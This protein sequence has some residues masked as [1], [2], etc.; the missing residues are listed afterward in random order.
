MPGPWSR[1]KRDKNKKKNPVKKLNVKNKQLREICT[2]DQKRLD[3]RKRL[4][5]N[6]KKYDEVEAERKELIKAKRAAN[7]QKVQSVPRLGIVTFEAARRKAKQVF[8][9]KQQK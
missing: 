2:Q 3:F 7:L 9:K 8:Q 6:W 5:E 4:T 1:N